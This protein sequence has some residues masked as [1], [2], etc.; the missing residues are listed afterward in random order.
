MANLF[1]QGKTQENYK[2]ALSINNHT[3]ISDANSADGGGSEAPSPKDLF[4]SSVAGCKLMTMKMYVDRKG[5]EVDAINIEM[6][7]DTSSKEDF[8]IKQAIHIASSLD[9]DQVKRIKNIAE[10]CPVAKYIK[11]GVT[12]KTS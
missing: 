6:E 11:Q 3:I 2:V 4:L 10:L 1:I 12:F 5:W 8:V 9:E 7:F